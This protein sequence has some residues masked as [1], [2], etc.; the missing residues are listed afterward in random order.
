[1]LVWPVISCCVCVTLTYCP[2]PPSQRKGTGTKSPG[3]GCVKLS[4]ANK[5][6]Y[7]RQDVAWT[8]VSS[9]NKCTGCRC[10][11]VEACRTESSAS[12]PQCETP[13][14]CEDLEGRKRCQSMKK[15]FARKMENTVQINFDAPLPASAVE[16]LAFAESFR[17][18]LGA[19]CTVLCRVGGAEDMSFHTNGISIIVPARIRGIREVISLSHTC[20]PPL[21][22]SSSFE[23]T[24]VSTAPSSFLFF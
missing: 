3:E 15:C 12:A 17:A 10:N 14:T 2:T 11:K 4:N 6:M 1:V 20:Q 9:A 18:K 16:Q 5:G 13:Y 21:P 23:H 24:H 7:F 8:G 22:L 19:R